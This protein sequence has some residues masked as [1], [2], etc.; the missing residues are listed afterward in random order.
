ME[1]KQITSVYYLISKE[2]KNR[3]QMQGKICRTFYS[4]KRIRNVREY[5]DKEISDSDKNRTFPKRWIKDIQ[6]SE[7]KRLI[8]YKI[9]Q[10]GRDFT[11]LSNF[12]EELGKNNIK[13]IKINQDFYFTKLEDRFM[14]G[15]LII[16]SKFESEMISKKLTS[17]L[18]TR[19]EK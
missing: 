16:F 18:N 8:V 12:Y 14:L 4:K 7:A 17:E 9:D 3:I 2:C 15:I 13:L 11:Q 1:K 10:L 6:N 19:R 5:I